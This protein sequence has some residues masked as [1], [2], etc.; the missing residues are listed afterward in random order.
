MLKLA[1]LCVCA[2]S[3]SLQHTSFGATANSG[4][5]WVTQ[6]S[7]GKRAV[8]ILPDDHPAL[9]AT[10]LEAEQW[11]NTE[12]FLK[13]KQQFKEARKKEEDQQKGD[14]EKHD[15]QDQGEAQQE[16]QQHGERQQ[17]KQDGEK[18]QGQQ[19][20]QKDQTKDEKLDEHKNQTTPEVKQDD[21]DVMDLTAAGSLQTV[22]AAFLHVSTLFFLFRQNSKNGLSMQI[23]LHV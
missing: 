17:A 10:G 13:Y 12:F 19:G 7:T 2:I 8:F 15:Q 22:D 9:K 14:K 1:A 6:D 20:E 3:V 23:L 21:A 11:R 18:E 4:R 16:D 5:I